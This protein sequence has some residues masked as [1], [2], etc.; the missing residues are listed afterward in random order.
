M[1]GGIGALQPADADA[2]RRA[3]HPVIA[4]SPALESADK[5][6]K[7]FACSPNMYRHAS[8]VAIRKEAEPGRAGPVRRFCADPLLLFPPLLSR[9]TADG[10]ALALRV[11]DYIAGMTD[12][13]ALQEHRRL[14][15]DTRNSF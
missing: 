2:V 12:R 4:F 10:Q 6:I 1:A 7:A 14:F 11:T 5:A 3:G 15:D 9:V 8:V 13:F